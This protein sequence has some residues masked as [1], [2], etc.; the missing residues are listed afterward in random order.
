MKP[1]RCLVLAAAPHGAGAVT[2]AA[3]GVAN[4]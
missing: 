2:D 3:V 1:S 4:N